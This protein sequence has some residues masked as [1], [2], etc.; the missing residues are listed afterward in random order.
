MSGSGRVGSS[1]TR[2]TQ[3]L[4]GQ[5]AAAVAALESSSSE[6]DMTWEDFLASTDE[7]GDTA[8]AATATVASA[9][10]LGTRRPKQAPLPGVRVGANT[11]GGSALERRPPPPAQPSQPS[12]SMSREAPLHGHNGLAAEKAKE[13]VGGFGSELMPWRK[14][15]AVNVESD[16]SAPESVGSDAGGG[17]GGMKQVIWHMHFYVGVLNVSDGVGLFFFPFLRG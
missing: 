5:D 10:S 7:S 17:V 8:P 15:K 1:A 6:G 2:S 12:T 16:E 14:S 4:M 9:T 13:T 11:N 3:E